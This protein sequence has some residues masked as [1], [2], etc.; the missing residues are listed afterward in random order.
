MKVV[1]VL[2]KGQIVIP[3]EMRDKMGIKAGDEVMLEQT[4]SGS[5]YIFPS[6]KDRKEAV[7]ALLT[8]FERHGV[9]RTKESGTALLKKMRREDEEHYQKKYK[10]WLK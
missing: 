1:K 7:E 2:Q 3:K 8:L 9:R 5:I 6:P 10:K 4:Y